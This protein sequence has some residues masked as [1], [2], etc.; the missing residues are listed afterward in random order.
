MNLKVLRLVET[1][2]L[3]IT[4]MSFAILVPDH[5]AKQ[6]A[7]KALKQFIAVNEFTKS[8]IQC[9]GHSGLLRLHKN[10]LVTKCHF[11]VKS[12]HHIVIKVKLQASILT[13]PCMVK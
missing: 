11:L 4:S 12:V 10:K 2:T 5:S 1:V 6:G 3:T 13:R 8:V 9:D 7:V